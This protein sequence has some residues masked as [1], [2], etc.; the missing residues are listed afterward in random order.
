VLLI[1]VMTV[2]VYV[3]VPLIKYGSYRVEVIGAMRD[4]LVTVDKEAKDA[5]VVLLIVVV[6]VFVFEKYVV[7]GISRRTTYSLLAGKR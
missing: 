7:T 6:I 3:V 4:T 1:T 2:F 5:T